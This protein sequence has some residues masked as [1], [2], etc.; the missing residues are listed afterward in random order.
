MRLG[1]GGRLAAIA[2]IVAPLGFVLDCRMWGMA[3]GPNLPGRCAMFAGDYAMPDN[4]LQM[5]ITPDWY[6]LPLFGMLRSVALD[7]G[8]VGPKTL[9]LIVMYSSF[10]APFALVFFNWRGVPQRAW[11]SLALVP[12]ILFGLGWTATRMPTE[13]VTTIGAMLTFAYFA[14]FL[15]IFP[16]LAQS[17]AHTTPETFD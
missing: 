14:V 15:L 8:A 10:L 4:P 6:L 3:L 5:Q 7:L 11:L 17:R 13:P 16:L 1:W 2:A 12:A 9:G